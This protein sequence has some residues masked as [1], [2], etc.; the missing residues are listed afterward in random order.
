MKS[1]AKN[2]IP[3]GHFNPIYRDLLLVTAMGL[4]VAFA[5]VTVGFILFH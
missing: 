4:L 5:L 3:G 1:F 2:L